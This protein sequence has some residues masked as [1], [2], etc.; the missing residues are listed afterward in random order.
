[1]EA[2]R[3]KLVEKIIAD[4]ELPPEVIQ[5]LELIMSGELQLTDDQFPELTRAL[6]KAE[7]V[8]DGPHKIGGI[9]F[10]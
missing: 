7:D 2:G 6:L 3:R 10:R 5:T 1:M 8:G 9:I 4:R